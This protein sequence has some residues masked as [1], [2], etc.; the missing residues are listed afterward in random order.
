MQ[1]RLSNFSISI[2]QRNSNTNTEYYEW[3]RWGKKEYV[4]TEIWEIFEVCQN[5]LCLRYAD[6][7]ICRAL[8]QNKNGSFKNAL[9]ISAINIFLQSAIV[10]ET[11]PYLLSQ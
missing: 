6:Y 3:Q 1:V 9:S 4:N 7:T 8:P 5:F 2:L 10:L 11:I